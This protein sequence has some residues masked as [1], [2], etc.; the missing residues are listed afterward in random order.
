MVKCCLWGLLEI[1]KFYAYFRSGLVKWSLALPRI[2]RKGFRI[3]PRRVIASPPPQGQEIGKHCLNIF[4][5]ILDPVFYYQVNHYES[6]ISYAT[7][8]KGTLKS[9]QTVSVKI[10][11]A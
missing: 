4:L 3:G 11:L 7:Y 8:G 10:Y 2:V 6:N 9:S 1:V 5:I